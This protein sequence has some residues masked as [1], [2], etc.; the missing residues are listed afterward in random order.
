[1]SAA[2]VK[3]NSKRFMALPPSVTGSPS[4]RFTNLQKTSKQKV[5]LQSMMQ[6]NHFST[7]KGFLYC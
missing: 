7:H 1:M 5:V 2:T 6:M 4:A 3:I